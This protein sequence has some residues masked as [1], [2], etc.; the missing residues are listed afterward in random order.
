V[1]GLRSLIARTGVPWWRV[2]T[3]VCGAGLYAI[4]LSEGAYELTTPVAMPHHALARKILAV[5]AFALLGFL[6][7][8]ADVRRLRGVA[9]AAVAIGLYSLAIEVGQV[10][11]DRSGESLASHLFDV[12]SGVAGGALGAFIAVLISAPSARA[13]RTEAIANALAFIV[14]AWGFTVT[15]GPTD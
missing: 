4:A 3:V 7:H 8:N 10:S 9:P 11:I 14:L 13:R 1:N 15:Y 6:L 2:L 12:A 5:L